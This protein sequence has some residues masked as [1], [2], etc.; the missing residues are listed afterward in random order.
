VNA[1]IVIIAIT[2]TATMTATT[3]MTVVT[4]MVAADLHCLR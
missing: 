4:G 3:A 1:A 2:D